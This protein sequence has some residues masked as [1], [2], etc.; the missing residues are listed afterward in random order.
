MKLHS[1]FTLFFQNST[2]FVLGAPGVFYWQ[3]KQNTSS[4]HQVYDVVSRI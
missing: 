1:T 4:D 2:E 3:G